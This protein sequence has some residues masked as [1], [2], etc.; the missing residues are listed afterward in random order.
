M[1]R[2]RTLLLIGLLAF[3]AATLAARGALIA[4][5]GLR[6]EYIADAPNG[7]QVRYLVDRDITTS[8]I[9]KAWNGTPPARFLVRWSGFLVVGRAGAYTFATTS[10]DGSTVTIDGQLIVDNRGEHAARMQS[11]RIQLAPG[12]HPLQIEYSQAGGGY[13][14]SWSW[15]RD[16][17]TLSPVSSWALW[18]RRTPYWRAMAARVVD[19]M[20]LVTL[21][22]FLLVVASTLWQAKGH[23]LVVAVNE[24]VGAR[25]LLRLFL[26]VASLVFAVGSAEWAARMIFRHVQSSGDAR[27]F[28][29]SRGNVTRVNNVG[30]RDPDVPTDH[31]GRYR[32]I[33]IGDSITWGQG[34]TEEQRFSNLLQQALGRGYDVVNF[35]IPAHNIPEHLQVLERA[36][37]LA[38][39]FI[40][41]QLYTNDFE[42]GE[43]E[44][45]MPH[46]LLPSA[47][48]DAWL[49]RSSALYT[50]L[51]AQWP[52]LQVKLGLAESYEHYM[53]KYLGDPQSPVS[54]KAFGMLHAFIRRARAA[55]VPCGTVM[56][57][58]PGFLGKTYALAYLHDRVRE[59]CTQERIR[60]VDLRDPFLSNFRDL[61]EIVVSP[62]D[63]HPSASANRVAADAI[64]NEFKSAWQGQERPSSHSGES[65]G[66]TASFLAQR[67][68]VPAGTPHERARQ[69]VEQSDE[70]G[71]V[72]VGL[73][74]AMKPGSHGKPLRN[75]VH[76]RKPS[77]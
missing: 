39:D 32:I 59:I 8:A 20:A 55:G 48:L 22:G 75:D 63:G 35:G 51:A 28:F 50:L 42:I 10:D 6:A 36:L 45:P 3:L 5:I 16:D 33:V 66:S 76:V 44:R 17:V 67:H 77:E 65:A 7:R 54:Q 52:Q 1:T 56:F 47:S 69:R 31:P 24:R 43:M 26:A 19:P 4:G 40:L 53:Y 23:D 15:G 41:L 29:A 2:K 34:L 27:T 9:T 25:V 18:T 11:G 72:E 70:Q 61:N 57:P 30:F 46:R 38:P 73:H 64:L 71:V 74:A 58:N 62:F 12:A 49:L 60:C 14:M 37:P 68:Q 21:I 13:E